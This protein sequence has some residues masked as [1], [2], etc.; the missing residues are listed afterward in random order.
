MFQPLCI[1]CERLPRSTEPR[2][3]NLRLCAV[4]AANRGWRNIYRKRPGWTREHDR[5]I[6]EMVERAKAKLPL[7]DEP[8]A[9]SGSPPVLS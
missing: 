4:C 6:Q 1:H 2:H 9:C 8:A 3:K 7:F 5:R